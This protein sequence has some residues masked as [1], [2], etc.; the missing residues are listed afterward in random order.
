VSFLSSTT[1]FIVHQPTFAVRMTEK[2]NSRF[3][4]NRILKSSGISA[5]TTID[6]FSHSH[7]KNRLV[8]D[9][10]GGQ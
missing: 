6:L 9:K 3:R 10:N 8:H 1:V 2:V 5:Q 7:S 4:R